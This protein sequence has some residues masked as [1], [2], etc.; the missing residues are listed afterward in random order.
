MPGSRST[1]T[2]LEDVQDERDVALW[3]LAADLDLWIHSAPGERTLFPSGRAS[4]DP[5]IFPAELRPELAALSVIHTNPERS[6]PLRLAGA[7]EAVWMWAE[8]M[9]WPEVAIHYAELA[10]RI[11][12]E[13]PDRSGTAGRLCRTGG[14]THRASIWYLRAARLARVQGKQIEFAE[15]HLGLGNL[16]SDLGHLTVA[17]RHQEKALRAAI[18]V[19]KRSLAMY[20]Y[21]NLLLLKLYAE[22]FDEAWIYAKDA[23]SIY[24]RDHPRL[25]ALAHDIALLCSR[26]GY[27]SSAI[28]VF[29]AVLPTMGRLSERMI[30]L[31]N[32]ARAAAA[33]HDRLRYE[34]AA[35]ELLSA[36][37]AGRSVPVSARY[38]LAC[39]AHTYEDWSRAES[40]I[41]GVLATGPEGH[42]LP[43]AQSLADAIRERTPGETDH[44]PLAG[45]E[46][47]SVREDLL[48]RLK[49]YATP[50]SEPGTAPPERY[51]LI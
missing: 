1:F 41:T 28:P 11:E 26:M 4:F 3:S 24:T 7:C 21:H 45:S 8:Q 18:S 25:P 35:R 15:A 34:R 43:L 39:A 27:N 17:Q 50:G 48:R 44:I 38:N 40:L 9:E 32:V 31:A 30:V 23:L 20:A 5:Q 46:I 29:E 37:E 42:Y 49:K 16:A 13:R 10:A 12:P 47:D 2:I 22:K 33:C 19:G 51:P 14:D 36:I 6:A